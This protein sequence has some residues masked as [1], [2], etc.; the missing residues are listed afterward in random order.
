LL[1][2]FSNSDKLFS[3]RSRSIPLAPRLDYAV[4]ALTKGL[5]I[6]EALATASTPLT[7]ALLAKELGRGNSEIFRMANLLE[8]RGY[9]ARDPAG[10]YLLTLKLFQ[11]GQSV[12]PTLSLVAAAR[13]PMR[14][15]CRKTGQ[16]CH[17]SMMEDGQL[18][19]LAQEFGTQA[20]TI[21][22]RPGFA[23]NPLRT[24]SGRLLL[25]ILDPEEAA[26]HFALARAAFPGPHPARANFFT[27]L[28]PLAK[29]GF[30]R[31]EGESLA[32]LCDVAVPLSA[33]SVKAA[34]ASSR[35]SGGLSAAEFAAWLDALR[36]AVA[37]VEN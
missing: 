12:N 5:D 19:V 35:F 31:A 25:A 28:K 9:I 24:A 14:E 15:F 29:A 33:G 34:L 8:A 26:R 7:L 37:D 1:A 36:Q 20:V 18:V 6:L 13:E 21:R 22:I 17:L 32:G 2:I 23:H 11:L 27:S 4:P 3:M 16:E 10:G 30:A